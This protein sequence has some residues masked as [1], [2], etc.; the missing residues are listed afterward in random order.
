MEVAAFLSDKTKSVTITGRS[1]FPFS[2]VLGN[3]IGNRIQKASQ[4]FISK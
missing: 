2:N 4:F 1:D 3:T